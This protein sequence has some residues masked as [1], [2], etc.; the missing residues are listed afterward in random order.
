MLILKSFSP[1]SYQVPF[2]L[3]TTVLDW[4]MAKIMVEELAH[5]S[6]TW[7]HTYISTVV[8]TGAAGAIKQG[9]QDT[10]LVTTK[11]IMI[12]PLVV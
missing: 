4:A 5:A 6:S 2:Q 12:P 1:F 7:H 3:G 9:C 10:L 8:T 11:S